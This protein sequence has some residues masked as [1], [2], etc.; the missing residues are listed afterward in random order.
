MTKHQEKL[1]FKTYPLSIFDNKDIIMEHSIV[2]YYDA[3]DLND[4][5]IIKR[6]TKTTKIIYD[7]K[8]C[9]KRRDVTLGDIMV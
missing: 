6:N 8:N 9:Y 7:R 3:E 4:F 1:K 5:T 2:L